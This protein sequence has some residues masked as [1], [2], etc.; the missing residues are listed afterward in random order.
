VPP[1]TSFAAEPVTAIVAAMEE[2]IAALRVRLHDARPALVGGARVTLGRLGRTS[3]ALAVTGDGERNAR[4]GLAALLA[5]LPV[6]R[7]IV[8]GVAGGLSEEL[9]GGALVIVDRVLD[10][11]DG[12][13]YVADADLAAAAAR[14]C[15]APRAIAVA[16]ARIADSA[17]EKRRLLALARAADVDTRGAA[18]SPTAPSTAPSLPPSLPQPLSPVPSPAVV[19]L[20]SAAFAAAAR[21]A[22][23]PWLVV[24]A[25]SDTAGESVP[26]LLNRSRDAGGAVRRGRVVLGLLADPGAVRPLLALRERVRACADALARAV[27]LTIEALATDTAGA[28]NPAPAPAIHSPTDTSHN[29]LERR[30]S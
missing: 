22:G 28:G 13:V 19:D 26:A 12:N 30:D 4:R 17:A 6:R 5:V 11:S 18:V 1:A 7:L 3:V 25:V 29:P 21:R 20:E 27:E 2:E 24:R 9:Q 16:A 8:A 15:A 23:I 14:A 10:E